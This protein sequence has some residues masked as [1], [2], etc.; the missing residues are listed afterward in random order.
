MVNHIYPARR[1]LTRTMK[2][3]TQNHLFFTTAG[4]V[5][6][7]YMIILARLFLVS[8]AILLPIALIE[9]HSAITINTK[10]LET[11]LLIQRLLF[12]P[13]GLGYFDTILQQAPIGVIDLSKLE[14]ASKNPSYLNTLAQYPNPH[15]G[16]KITIGSLTSYYHKPLYDD[17]SILSQTRLPG[18]GGADRFETTIPVL[19]RTPQSDTP[20][21]AHVEVIT[22]R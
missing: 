22:P 10:S 2:T 16:A 1:F 21:T 15:F 11:E 12:S 4:M 5:T 17:Y 18:R 20:A 9:S 19:L 3:R 8:L 13:S 14:A 6:L 7:D